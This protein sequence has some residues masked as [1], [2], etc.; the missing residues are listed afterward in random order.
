M[1]IVIC[2]FWR[3]PL[4]FVT[5]FIH[6]V[7]C[8]FL[9]TAYNFWHPIDTHCYLSF[10]GD[11][12][13]FLPPNS[14]TLLSV[15]FWRHPSIFATQLINIVICQFLKTTFNFYYSIH[16]HRYCFFETAFNFWHPIHAHCY[17]SFFEDSLQFLLPN[18]YTLL[19]VI[20]WRQPSV[21]ATQFIHMVICYFLETAFS[22]CHPIHTHCYPSFFEESLQ[23]LPPNWYT[24]LYVIFWRQPSIFDTHLIHIVICHFLETAFYFTGISLSCKVLRSNP[25]PEY[26]GWTLQ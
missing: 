8:H 17:L 23:F 20:F 10:F 3:Q 13:Q 21:F 5:Q 24:I 7:I 18:S 22:F 2:H 19:S 16:T 12:L 9:K 6:I 15:I 14:Y 4:I 1:R 25:D 26:S 11:S